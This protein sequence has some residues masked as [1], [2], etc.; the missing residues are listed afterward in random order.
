MSQAPAFTV[1]KEYLLAEAHTRGVTPQSQSA[2]PVSRKAAPPIM[3][4]I[5]NGADEPTS[6]LDP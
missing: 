6:I 3:M 1:F 4:M 2:G 5:A